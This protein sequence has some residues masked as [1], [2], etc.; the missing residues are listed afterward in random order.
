MVSLGACQKADKKSSDKDT[1]AAKAT[2]GNKKAGASRPDKTTKGPKP[3]DLPA[4][5]DVA[6]P[7]S[8]ALKTENGV[9]YKVLTPAKAAGD[10]PTVN[11]T[12]EVHYTGWTTDGVMF[13][14]S[15]KR[16][17]PA[18]I[19]LG[20]VIPGWTE[21]LQVMSIGE[22]TRFW[23]PEEL[24]YK[25]RRGSP[26]G[27]LVFDVELLSIKKAP[28]APAD[29]AAP[30][31]D[32]RKTGLGVS[33]RVLKSGD[34]GEKPREWDK[35]EVHYS[36]WT[37][38]G[39]MFDSSITRGRPA[40]FAVN[41][42]IAGWTDVLQQMSPGDK[43]LIWIP[44]EHAYKGQ[45]R[46]PSGTLV[47]EVELLKVTAMPEPPKAPADVA[48]PPKD[49]KKTEKGVSYKV[50]ETGDGGAKPLPTDKVEVHYSGWTT[51]GK[52]F[53]SSVTRGRPITFPLTTVI[54][55]WTDGLQ[56]MGVGDKVR[57]WIPEELAYKGQ[58]GKPAGML[59]FD[60]ELV[61]IKKPI[62]KKPGAGV[63]NPHAPKPAAV[64]AQ[65]AKK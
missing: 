65:A 37:T 48:A 32:A 28:E 33:Y 8:D 29:V 2:D 22:K 41:G 36:G 13:D 25:G 7:P 52:M 53:D 21:G 5:S 34:G 23:I 9:S 20:K 57:F 58:P 54:P 39:K 15:V 64:K 47:F 56:V 10:K 18:T 60:V 59:V 45:P 12:V 30:P 3:G 63:A 24:A 31:A 1:E 43:W 35:V 14:S 11:D 55:G 46:K 38:D 27:M 4:P 51:D 44:E 49:A 61:S 19:G 40:Q 42:V 6:A 50:L 16:G 17:K 62:A 26:A